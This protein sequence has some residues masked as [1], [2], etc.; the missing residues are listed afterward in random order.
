M[1]AIIYLSVLLLHACASVT[2]P[3][4]TI[5]LNDVSQYRLQTVPATLQGTARLERLSIHTPTDKK[6]LLI[7]IEMYTS[8][9]EFVGLSSA[10]LVLF[11]MSW[12]ANSGYQVS[13]KV[14]T[15][16]LNPALLLA[17]FQL[18]NWPPALIKKGLTGLTLI[19]EKEHSKRD[20]QHQGK[21]LFSVS[22]TNNNRLFIHNEPP[23]SIVIETLKAWEIEG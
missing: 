22:E 13:M 20:F 3:S 15:D 10:G 17:Y 2:P 9:I 16:N 7:Q 1:R 8:H 23:F 4:D 12:Q 19:Q 6:E 14:P 21:S 5:P 11:E 18:A